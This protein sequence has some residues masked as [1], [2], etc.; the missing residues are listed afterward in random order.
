MSTL[1]PIFDG[2]LAATGTPAGDPF[3]Q[4]FLTSAGFGGLMALTAALIAARIAAMQLRHTK[5]QQQ[6]ERWWSTLT[7]VYDRA[8]VDGDKR[9]ALP[10]HVTFAMLSQLAER[11]QLPPEDR[12]QQ[13]AIRSIL[14]MFEP[15]GA[16]DR[17][18]AASAATAGKTFQVSDPSAMALL[19]ELRDKLSTDAELM[20]RAE[21]LRFMEA[22]KKVIKREAELLGATTGAS[23]HGDVVATWSARDILVRIH[24]AEKNLSNGAVFLAIERL[25]ID[26]AADYHAIGGILVLNAPP[27]RPAVDEFLA[28]KH[29]PRVEV[30]V[31]HDEDDDPTIHDALQRLRPP[32]TAV[33]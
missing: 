6:H 30:V 1:R 18:Q 13:S 28:R 3:W 23:R 16:G 22:A 21:Q 10:H 4:R 33:G 15:A 8:V 5:S 31:W 24:H 27:N 26:I 32:G 7:W 20:A 25:E 9:A 12:L 17:D 11:A 19:D 14:S 2:L 29:G